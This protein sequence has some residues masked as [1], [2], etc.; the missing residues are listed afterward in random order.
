M[1]V[2]CNKS[3]CVDICDVWCLE[4]VL[5]HQDALLTKIWV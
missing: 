5:G 3:L 2:N 1:N 4:E